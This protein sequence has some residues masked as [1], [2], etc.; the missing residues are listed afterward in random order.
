MESFARARP[1][2]PTDPQERGSIV[3]QCS[4]RRRSLFPDTYTYPYQSSIIA[5]AETQRTVYTTATRLLVQPVLL[6]RCM[7]EVVDPTLSWSHGPLADYVHASLPG[8]EYS[9]RTCRER[10]CAAFSDLDQ[11]GLHHAHVMRV[12]YTAAF[13][14]WGRLLTLRCPTKPAALGGDL[15]SS[16]ES[17]LAPAF[18]ERMRQLPENLCIYRSWHPAAR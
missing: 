7:L 18:L 4:T 15:F 9:P 2:R 8:S 14:G 1:P 3:G 12:I 10:R 5:I 6:P 17:S 11:H 13:V 16:P